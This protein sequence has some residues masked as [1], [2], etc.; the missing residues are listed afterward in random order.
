MHTGCGDGILWF[1]NHFDGQ[2][3]TT[4]A[5]GSVI[6]GGSQAFQTGFGGRS[7]AGLEVSRGDFLYLLVDP[8]QQGVSC[9]STGLSI[10]ITPNG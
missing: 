9:D 1:I 6:N 7:L 4:V 2:T 3:S 5:S 10:V 8:I